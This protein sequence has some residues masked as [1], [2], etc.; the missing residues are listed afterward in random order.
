M[1]KLDSAIVVE[2]VNL[3][4][5]NGTLLPQIATNNNEK[6]AS[7]FSK[8]SSKEILSEPVVILYKRNKPRYL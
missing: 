8:G 1:G 7:S 3:L 6:D 2:I 5:F 4:E